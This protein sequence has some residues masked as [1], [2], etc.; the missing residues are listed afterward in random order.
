MLRERRE[1]RLLIVGGD[2]DKLCGC[3]GR[4]RGLVQHALLSNKMSHP[5][6]QD[7]SLIWKFSISAGLKADGLIVP[8][9]LAF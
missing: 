3:P 6:D 4:G 8:F 9:K 2:E 5:R 1:S 7:A